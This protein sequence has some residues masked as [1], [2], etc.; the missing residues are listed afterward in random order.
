MEQHD[1]QPRKLPR[2]SRSI[3]TVD[4][5]VQATLELL[6]RDDD[7]GTTTT[8]VALRAGVSVGTLYQYFPHQDA[9]R[10]A[11][12]QRHLDHLAAALEQLC[13]QHRNKPLVSLAHDFA[14]GYAELK[15]A[16]A[17]DRLTLQHHMAELGM[18][19]AK[20]MVS[21][22]ARTAMGELLRSASDASFGDA[23]TTASALLD[24]MHDMVWTA[25]RQPGEAS[26]LVKLRR[27]L[28]AVARRHLGVQAPTR[29]T[30]EMRIA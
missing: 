26:R 11:A 6:K 9:L 8:R 13:M 24:E 7:G 12:L 10:F 20:A 18:E 17:G 23:G 4:A 1:F 27:D 2:Q 30:V 22:R 21:Q 16:R 15:I 19:Q 25:L 28:P 5:M 14:A 3:M 29:R